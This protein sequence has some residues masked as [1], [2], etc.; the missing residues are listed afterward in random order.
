M[1]STR[2]LGGWMSLISTR[3]TLDAPGADGFVH[4]LEEPVVDR[5]AVRQQL[6]EIH[7]AHDRT[8][9]GHRQV[10]DGDFQIGDLVGGLRGVQAPD[11][12]QTASAEDTGI[13]LGDDFLGRDIEHL[14]HHVHLGADAFDERKDEVKAGLQ[15]L[16]IASEALD[17]IAIALR[18]GLDPREE[19]RK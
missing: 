18:H 3:V 9:V 14:L 6:V 17:G 4:H 16:R 10:Q 1:A 13:I 15:R 2:S 8:D 12:R 19:G 11:R 7:G 5:F